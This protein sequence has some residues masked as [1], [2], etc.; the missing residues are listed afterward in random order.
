MPEHVQPKIPD[1]V[2][3]LSLGD[4]RAYMALFEIFTPKIYRT[5]RKMF[6]LH[7]DA[8]EIVQ[9]VFMRVWHYR[10]NLDY[11]LSFNAYVLTIMKSLIFKRTKKMALEAAFK[12]YNIGHLPT[13]GNITEEEL[14]HK[15]MIKFSKMA[16]STLPKGQQEVI[17]LKYLEQLSSDEI[18]TKLQ[19]SKRTVEN[20]IY[21]ATK[22]LKQQ[23]LNNHIVPSDILMLFIV[24]MNI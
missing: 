21:K 19:L 11:K 9:E 1:L 2:K 12:Q 6:L 22:S 16:I 23:I 20:Q 5:C 7:E 13:C 14:F 18:A 24:F 17:N 15:E 4:E 3:K 8:E 10:V